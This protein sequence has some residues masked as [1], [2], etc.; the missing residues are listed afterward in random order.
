MVEEVPDG[1][2][3]CSERKEKVQTI[4]EMWQTGLGLWFTKNF[5]AS[6][7]KQSSNG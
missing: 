6:L 2:N 7:V 3:T 1:L 4:A 5:R